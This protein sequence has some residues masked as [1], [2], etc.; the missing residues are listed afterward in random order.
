MHREGQDRRK[1][2]STLEIREDNERRV[3]NEVAKYKDETYRER[4]KRVEVEKA[5]AEEKRVNEDCARWANEFVGCIV[6]PL[7]QQAGDDNQTGVGGDAKTS[8]AGELQEIMRR[9]VAATQNQ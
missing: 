7:G 9:I 6:R 1:A 5:Y 8:S 4:A 2:R 3:A